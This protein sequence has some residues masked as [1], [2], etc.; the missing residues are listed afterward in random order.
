MHGSS[1]LDST[2]NKI[3]NIGRLKRM[4]STILKRCTLV[5]TVSEKYMILLHKQFP[6]YESK[7]YFLTNGVS[8]DFSYIKKI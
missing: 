5:L 1:Y 6:N 3:D 7:I 4:E 8:A 2:V